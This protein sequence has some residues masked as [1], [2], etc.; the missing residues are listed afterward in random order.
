MVPETAPASRPIAVLIAIE[1][2]RD[3]AMSATR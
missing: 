3:R 1:E 2:A